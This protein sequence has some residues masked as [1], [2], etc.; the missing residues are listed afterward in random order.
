MEGGYM[1]TRRRTT[2]PPRKRFTTGFTDLSQAEMQTL[3]D[4]FD[5]VGTWDTFN[6]ID[7]TTSIVYVVRFS[8]EFVAKYKGIADYFRYDVP[9]IKLLQA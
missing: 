7:P 5:D 9:T 1:H 2:R 4:F 3:E 8:S 6:W